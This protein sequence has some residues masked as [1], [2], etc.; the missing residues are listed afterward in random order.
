[1]VNENGRVADVMSPDVKTLG[2]NDKLASADDIM[3]QNRI[4]H[5]PVVD[6]DG[7][8]CGIISQRDLFRGMLLRTLG[9]GTHLEQK[10]L[11][12]HAIKEAMVD[13]VHTTTPDASLKEAA[14]LMITHKVG[15]LPV[16]DNGK[17]VGIITEENF[18]KLFASS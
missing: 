13:H 15:C 2:R 3:K 5:L 8:L 6:Q 18:L 16:L 17:L 14:Q 9:Y 10:M 4:R 1:M 12:T 7:N 11:D